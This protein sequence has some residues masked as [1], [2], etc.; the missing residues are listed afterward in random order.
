[1]KLS[2]YKKY[3]GM[4]LCL[5][6]VFVIGCGGSYNAEKMHWH[7]NKTHGKIIK[8][9]AEAN[10][11]EFNDTVKSLREIVKKYP[12]WNYSAEIQFH[13]GRLYAS[14][15]KFDN[16]RKELMKVIMNFP[17]KSELCA[18]SR[19]FI[20]GLYER[21]GDWEKALSDYEQVT[22]RYPNTYVGIQCPLYIADYYRKH[23]MKEE[24]EKAYTMAIRRYN[25]I[26]EINPYSKQVPVVHELIMLAYGRQGKWNELINSLQR[27]AD[28]Y[29]KT[30]AAPA[31]L[32]MIASVYRNI[33]K[34]PD[35]AEE[36]YRRITSVYPENNIGKNAQFEIVNLSI[37]KGDME[38]AEKEFKKIQEEYPDDV[39]INTAAQFA[40]AAGYEKTGNWDYALREYKKLQNEY[41]ETVEALK[42]PIVI[43]HH[44]QKTEQ[45][46]KAEEAFNEAIA[47]YKVIIQNKSEKEIT[48]V[49]REL[50]A[51]VYVMQKRWNNAIKELSLLRKKYPGDPRAALVLFKMAGIYK[52]ELKDSARA[53]DT[54]SKFLKEYPDHELAEA[55]R[56]SLDNLNETR[57]EY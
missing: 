35:K 25:S 12:A 46:S 19:F 5:S 42:V 47:V 11:Q 17:E 3:S 40:I 55:A 6:L 13:I 15:K 28:K 54:Y 30:E 9:P 4:L 57:S 26:I 36:I 48:V 29:P 44:Y 39:A 49:A 38:T 34:K 51:K 10:E 31:A 24:S 2:L 16:A 27:F 43:A 20:G 37:L 1:M 22:E 21:Q 41:P 50:T 23:N 56:N 18:R 32:Y 52:T 33:F 7:V 45:V 14:R 53:F 8:N